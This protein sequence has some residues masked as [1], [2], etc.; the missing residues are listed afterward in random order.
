MYAI[1]DNNKL[2]SK[3]MKPFSDPQ[4][5]FAFRIL[6]ER[7]VPIQDAVQPGDWL[8]VFDDGSGAAFRGTFPVVEVQENSVALAVSRSTVRCKP[9]ELHYPTVPAQWSERQRQVIDHLLQTRQHT[10]ILATGAGFM[11]AQGFPDYPALA[12]PL[13]VNYPGQFFWRASAT[14]AAQDL[15][16]FGLGQTRYA[17]VVWMDSEVVLGAMPD[18]PPRWMFTGKNLHVYGQTITPY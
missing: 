9:W 18:C 3:S 1:I 12:Q 8:T 4:V 6:T 14:E 2:D 11:G 17:I 15:Q 7:L 13:S 10:F 16:M 5:E